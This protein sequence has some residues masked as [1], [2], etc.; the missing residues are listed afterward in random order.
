MTASPAR[1]ELVVLLQRTGNGDREA[2]ADLH[3]RTSAKLFGIICRILPNRE[4][5]EEA[6]QDCFFNI[7]RDAGNYDRKIASPISWMAAIARNRAI[8]IR[9]LSAERV[10]SGSDAMVEDMISDTAGPLAAAERTEALRRLIICLGKL[11][12]DGRKM[13]LLAYF[14]GWSRQEIGEQ[15]SKPVNTVKTL[16]RRNLALLKGCLDGS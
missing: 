5:A 12:Q 14:Q 4:L 2:F 1:N 16:L 11:P 6:L 3:N 10:S 8:D 9:R 13:V 7:W 15:F